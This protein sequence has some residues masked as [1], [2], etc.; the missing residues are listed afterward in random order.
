MALPSW[1]IL[2]STPA[3]RKAKRLV[4]VFFLLAALMMVGSFVVWMHVQDPKQISI[5][6]PASSSLPTETISIHGKTF[7]L[8]IADTDAT[9]EQ[10]LSDRISLASDHGMLFLF[11]SPVQFPFWMPRMHFPLDIIFLREGKIVDFVKNIPAP[12]GDEPPARYQPTETYDQVLEVVVG[13]ID[14]LGLK[15]GDSLAIPSR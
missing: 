10:G 12:V 9:R 13:T 8:E 15:R 5:D 6:Q 1:Y 7:V 3:S 4:G 2:P 14:T 11:D